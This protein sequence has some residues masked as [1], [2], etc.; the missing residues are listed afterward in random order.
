MNPPTVKGF[1]P[2]GPEADNRNAEPVTLLFEEYEALRLCDYDLFYHHE[3]SEIMNVSRSTY[4][5]IYALARHKVAKAFVEGRPIVIEGGKVYFDSDWYHCHRCNCF[6][7]D[8]EKTATV[9]IC[10]LCGSREVGEVDAGHVPEQVPVSS[11]DDVCICISCGFELKHRPG[12]PCREEV[13]PECHGAMKR[14]RKQYRGNHQS[15]ST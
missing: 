11:N 7:N 6:F 15:S 5:R 2:Y 3:A 10:P 13:C 12:K 4:T 1:K 8:N 9:G 14:K